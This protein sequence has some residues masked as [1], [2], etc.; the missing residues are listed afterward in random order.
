[1][2]IFFI[3]KDCPADFFQFQRFGLLCHLF[4]IYWAS[5]PDIPII[6]FL[7]KGASFAFSLFPFDFF[8]TP[9]MRWVLTNEFCKSDFYWNTSL[10]T[11]LLERYV[12]VIFQGW[13][14]GWILPQLALVS[15]DKFPLKRKHIEAHF[16]LQFHSKWNNGK[17]FIQIHGNLSLCIQHEI[18]TSSIGLAQMFREER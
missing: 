14:M 9:E 5:S 17:G 1:M 7:P 16:R 8:F 2:P 6:R 4:F 13:I 11:K 10:K 12:Y 3:S 15:D 18:Y